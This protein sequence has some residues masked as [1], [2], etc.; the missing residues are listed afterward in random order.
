[1]A[2]LEKGAKEGLESRFNGMKR[3]S[4]QVRDAIQQVECL[5]PENIYGVK[6][7]PREQAV[8]F[9][10]L[11][12]PRLA[13]GRKTVGDEGSVRI[14]EDIDAPTARV[15]VHSHPYTGEHQTFEPSMADHIAARKYPHLEHV[16]Q[17]P[18]LGGANQYLIYSGATPP[19]YYHLAPN[20]GN[21]PIPRPDSPDGRMPPLRQLYDQ[22]G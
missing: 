15:I 6:R 17:A 20:P 3:M 2:D 16:I 14:P 13:A 1:M 7:E 12:Q 8:V 22:E 21:H 9:H 5:F 19:R 11:G 4:P 18:M 10:D